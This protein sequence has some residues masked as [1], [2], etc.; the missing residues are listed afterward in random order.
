MKVLVVFDSYFGNTE[1]IGKAIAK[2]IS[3]AE[4][5]RTKDISHSDLP[6]YELIIFGSP[7]R[8]F[9]PTEDILKLVKSIPKKGLAGIKV[10]VF[11]TR[12][13][14]ETIN[15]NFLR[16]FVDMGGYAAPTLKKMLCRKG[17]ESIIEPEGF[18]VMDTEGPLKDKEL[19]RA[20][21][22]G[23]KVMESFHQLNYK[24]AE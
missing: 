15:S 4:T 6:G 2:P 8:G 13:D 12:I 10:A 21:N 5:K 11:D 18:Y 19:E 3:N 17:A 24:P 7:T 14:L 1:E 20:E 22:W 16:K 23:S 9:R